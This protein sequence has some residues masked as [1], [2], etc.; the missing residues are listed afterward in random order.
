MIPQYANNVRHYGQHTPLLASA[1]GH[2]QQI[3]GVAYI[4]YATALAP[5]P[6][7][8]IFYDNPFAKAGPVDEKQPL[9]WYASY[10]RAGAATLA[11]HTFNMIDQDLMFTYSRDL[12]P[13]Y[14][15]PVGV[16]NHALIA[17]AAIGIAILIAGARRSRIRALGA[18]AALGYI[19]AHVALHATTAVEMRFG[20]PLLLLAGPAAVAAIFRLASRDAHRARM[21]AMATVS[22]YVIAA[23]ALSSWVREQAPS[24]RAWQAADNAAA[25]DESAVAAS[26]TLEAGTAT[27]R[28]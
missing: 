9:R 1:L 17:F 25:L 8:S 24:I 5:V 15:I 12:D 14:R 23:L 18:I 20:L 3:W 19:G 13:W 21:L 28:T 27:S 22:A 16:V 7:P 4:K 10:P 6:N 26:P 2:H 11:L